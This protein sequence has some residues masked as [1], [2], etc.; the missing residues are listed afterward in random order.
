MPCIERP[1]SIGFR[2]EELKDVF[3]HQF[4]NSAIFS[5]QEK[6]KLVPQLEN[7]A[8]NFRTHSGVVHVA[9]SIVKLLLHF[10]PQQMDKLEP[11]R[12]QVDGP[13][14]I[15]IKGSDDLITE[16]F[17]R[18]SMGSNCEFGS[19]Q[20]ILVRDEAT[21]VKLME[22]VGTNALVL[23]MLEAKG[24]EFSDC[25]VYNFF[26]SSPCKNDWRVLYDLSLIHI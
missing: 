23:T 12:A 25:L 19:E 15:F 20:V 7:L 8:V 17:G 21:K 16:L 26:L 18:G 14:P 22:Q 4:L 6:S 24:M 1:F 2:F 11:E 5:E 3:Y 13:V 9:N 10:F